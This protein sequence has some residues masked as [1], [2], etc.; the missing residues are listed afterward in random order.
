MNDNEVTYNSVQE[1]YQLLRDLLIIHGGS[2]TFVDEQIDTVA[3]VEHGDEIGFGTS[4]PNV[5]IWSVYLDGDLIMLHVFDHADGNMHSVN[6]GLDDI[7]G[8][9]IDLLVKAVG[10]NFRKLELNNNK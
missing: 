6:V 3:Y 9:D 2:C 4:M 8:T 5:K 7:P 1:H 10:D